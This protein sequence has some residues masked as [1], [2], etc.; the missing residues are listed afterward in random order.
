MNLVFGL[1]ILIPLSS[2]ALLQV[3]KYYVMSTSSSPH[4]TL[5]F[6][7]FMFS[8]SLPFLYVCSPLSLSV[9]I[10]LVSFHFPISPTL[11]IF[12]LSPSP[13]PSLG[14]SV[15]SNITCFVYLSLSLSLCMSSMV[16]YSCEMQSC[17]TTHSPVKRAELLR[18]SGHEL[19]KKLTPFIT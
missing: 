4:S 15:H 13:P 8:I 14:L 3:S 1:L 12:S 5:S 16:I 19:L 10:S 7:H 2:N 17:L 11:P 18:I 9:S 6:S